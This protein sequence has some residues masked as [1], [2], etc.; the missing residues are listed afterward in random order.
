MFH[1]VQGKY[2]GVFFGR[3]VF[4]PAHS[5][6]V[7]QLP[8]EPCKPCPWLQDLEESVTAVDKDAARILV[9]SVQPLCVPHP[10]SLS[11]VYLR[12]VLLNIADRCGPKARE[13]GHHG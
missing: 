1:S 9:R 10:C 8:R 12:S 5:C 11:H 2:L 13:D 7:R 6:F 3:L 4:Q